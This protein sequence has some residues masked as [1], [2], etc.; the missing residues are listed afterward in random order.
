MFARC[1]ICC[2]VVIAILVSLIPITLTIL[3]GVYA[4]GNPDQPAWYGLESGQ[5]SLYAS[6]ELAKAASAE[7]IVNIHGR[8][9]NWFFW[10]FLVF[11]SPFIITLLLVACVFVSPNTATVCGP[12][13]S[14]ATA[15]GSLVWYIL[16]IVWRFNSKGRYTA[17]D[18][19]PVGT[20][21]EAWAE[22]VAAAGSNFQLSSGKFMFVYYVVSWV[23]LAV[24]VLTSIVV[25]ILACCLCAQ[26]PD[27]EEAVIERPSEPFSATPGSAGDVNS[28]RSNDRKNE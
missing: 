21:K 12:V 2:A 24:A 1:G 25:V 8:F 13:L 6:E 16:G 22:Q 17:G 3:F 23:G 19:P 18:V 27:D 28:R 20:D 9:V 26:K 15:C 4:F 7:D 14:F 5:P 10:G 11:V